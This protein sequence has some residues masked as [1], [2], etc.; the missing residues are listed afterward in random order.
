MSGTM[1]IH[2]G[3]ITVDY[4]IILTHDCVFISM[5]VTKAFDD[6]MIF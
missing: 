1:K 3:K 4:V 2:D 5:P 6:T